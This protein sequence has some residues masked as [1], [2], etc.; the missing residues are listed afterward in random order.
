MHERINLLINASY[1]VCHNLETYLFENY[2]TANIRIILPH[3]ETDKH[4]VF[5]VPP[6][7][8]RH[9]VIGVTLSKLF[10]LKRYVPRAHFLN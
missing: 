7:S 2:P 8:L 3:Q 4:A 9:E 1:E 5:Y 6:E 10:G